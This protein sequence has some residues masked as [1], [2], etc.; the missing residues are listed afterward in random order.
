MDPK[1]YL[2]SLVIAALIGIPV[3]LLALGFVWLEQ[4]LTD[5]LWTTMPNHLGDSAPPWWWILLVPTV[6]GLLVAF[7]RLLP[8]DG[9]HDPAKGFSAVPTQPREIGGVMLAALIT[10]S[11]G[12]VLGPEAPLIALGSAFGLAIALVVRRGKAKAPLLA[13]TGSFASIASIFGNP[14]NTAFFMLEAGAPQGA[15]LV[16]ALVP[17]LLAAGV[18]YVVYTGTADWAGLPPIQLAIPGLP[19]YTS[20][21]LS[22]LLLAIVIGIAT[23]I[24]AA[25]V[26][27]SSRQLS[28]RVS[29]V[30]PFVVVP[31]AGL[32][33]GTC[34][35]IYT[36]ATGRP[37]SEVL[38]SGQTGLATE[39]AV[40]GV[41]TLLLLLVLK[42]V[43]YLVSLGGG[44]R[45]GPV[46]PALFLGVCV[47]TLVSVTTDMSI[48]ATTGAG[49]AAGMAAMLRLPL[50]GALFGLLMM[51][52]VGLDATPV[53]IV[54]ATV[55]YVA[56]LGLETAVAKRAA[57]GA[58][59]PA[60]PGP[61]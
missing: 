32:V 16:P 18:G 60:A 38:F 45:G 53:V 46:F 21:S 58:P 2:Q 19:E 12:A 52:S 44:F 31:L 24:V 23:A 36:E 59:P 7:A 30:S 11:C 42:A 25:F 50:S 26:H 56:D 39:V 10:L 57:A 40:T 4:H 8:G 35:V 43:A 28:T 17:G 22:D 37:V 48:T 20:V 1:T 29:R 9:G 5:F 54:A 34:A 47:G 49:V 55:A 27:A 6:G 61:A 15:M 41:G 14:V 51:G 3:A 13:S 33:V